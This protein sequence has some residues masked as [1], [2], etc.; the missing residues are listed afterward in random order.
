LRTA[1]ADMIHGKTGRRD[2]YAENVKKM[3]V[4]IEIFIPLIES[5]VLLGHS[6]CNSRL[7]A[8][9]IVREGRL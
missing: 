7:L 5:L 2:R 3:E 9:E 8:A 6:A 4:D 1:D